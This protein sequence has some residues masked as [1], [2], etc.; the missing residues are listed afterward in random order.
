M[1]RQKFIVAVIGG[2][3]CSTSEEMQAAMV[4]RLLA[5]NNAILIC[6]GHGGV[7]EAASGGVRAGGG[8][9]IG[10]LP[11]SSRDAANPYID[12][13]I[14]TGLGEA[15]NAII[16]NSADA[17]IAVGGGYGTLSELAF[18]LKR[19][20]PVVGL[21]TWQAHDP[22]QKELSIIAVGSAEEAVETVMTM[23]EAK[24]D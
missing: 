5:E 13:P 16:I 7:M 23:L 10:V 6:G 22:Q 15:R 21:N 24:S 9:T 1:D 14:V 2:A 11:G 8:L 19:G 12:I 20:I 18:A 4:G 3:E 17:V